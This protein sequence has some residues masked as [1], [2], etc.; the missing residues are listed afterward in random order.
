MRNNQFRKVKVFGFVPFDDGILVFGLF[1]I[2]KQK[3]FAKIAET[4]TK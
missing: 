4:R 3:W 1:L 2:P